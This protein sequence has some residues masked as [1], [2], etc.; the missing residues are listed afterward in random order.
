MSKRRVVITGLGTINAIGNN[1]RDTWENLVAGKS[2][3]SKITKIED[4]ESFSSQIGGEIKNFEQHDEKFITIKVSEKVRV[5]DKFY[6]I[7]KR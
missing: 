2:G 4:I 1:V 5:N 7:K 6:L 3:I